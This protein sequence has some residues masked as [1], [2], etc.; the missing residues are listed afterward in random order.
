LAQFAQQAF[1]HLLRKP[2]KRHA[3]NIRSTDLVVPWA[4]RSGPLLVLEILNDDMP[5]AVESVMAELHSRGLVP[6]L[7]FHPIF[8][9]KRY[10]SGRLQG[11]VAPGDK[12]WVSGDQESYIAV[13][14]APIDEPAQRD[15]VQGL[16]LVL[17]DVRHT[18]TDAEAMRS[19]LNQAIAAS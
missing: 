10:G 17:E 18:A 2:H 14:L 7:V 16:D 5:F 3:I 9:V 13:V 15:L 12:N 1:A 6:R 11:I 4:R 8:K 19:R